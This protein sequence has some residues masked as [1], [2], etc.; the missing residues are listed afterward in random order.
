M[1][2]ATE[3]SGRYRGKRRAARPA[4]TRAAMVVALLA[5]LLVGACGSLAM[6]YNVQLGDVDRITALG[7]YSDRP[8]RS[9]SAGDALN[10]LLMG[11]DNGNGSSIKEELADGEW[12]VGSHRSDTI[13]ILHIT[14][15]RDA[16]YLVSIPRDSYVRIPEHGHDKIN[17]AFSYGGPALAQRTVEQLTDV[18][19]DHLVMIDWASFKDLT[20]ALGGVPVTI[21]DTFTDPKTGTWKAGTYNLQGERALAYV[22]TRYGLENG[23]FDRIKRQQNFL[24]ALLRKT[25]SQGT[26]SNPVR[27]TNVL[28][29]LTDNVT[30]DE[31][32]DVG[33]MR[34]LALSL[35]GLRGD[36]VEYLTAPLGRYDEVDGQSVVRLKRRESQALFDAVRMDDIDSYLRRYGGDQLPAPGSVD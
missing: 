4:R 27:L 10:I 14:A 28:E 26:V 8:G 19:M 1:A 36:D 2:H 35:R 20:T 9:E 21:S 25:L 16:A 18:R 31:E 7:D 29:V 5:T 17:A 34:G 3:R 23:D 11:T 22:R 12:E 6:Y 33:E 24:R 32:F 30:V 15:D 13:M